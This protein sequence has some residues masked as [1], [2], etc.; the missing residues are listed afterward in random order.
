MFRECV[1][2]VG[3]TPELNLN[4]SSNQREADFHTVFSRLW[5]G[6]RFMASLRFDIYSTLAVN[7]DQVHT[8]LNSDMGIVAV[9]Y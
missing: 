6:W 9:L 5:R 4:M 7:T 1:E 2:G 8:G 3:S